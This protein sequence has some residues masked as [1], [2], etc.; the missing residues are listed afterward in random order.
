MK[1]IEKLFLFDLHRDVC[2]T[3]K[4]SHLLLLKFHNIIQKIDYNLGHIFV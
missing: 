4:G 3:T 1:L 2:I